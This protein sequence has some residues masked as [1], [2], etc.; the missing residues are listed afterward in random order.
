MRGLGVLKCFAACCP[1]SRALE[2]R[3]RRTG[4]PLERRNPS[5]CAVTKIECALGVWPML[6]RFAFGARSDVLVYDAALF[7]EV[8]PSVQLPKAHQ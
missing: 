8:G 3:R 2:A 6:S 4:I 5:H 7:G 1:A